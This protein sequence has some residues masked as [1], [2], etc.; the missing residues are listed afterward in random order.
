MR[1]KKINIRFFLTVIIFGSWL[2]PAKNTPFK[3]SMIFTFYFDG[4][5]KLK[6]IL[7]T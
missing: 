6:N 4:S 2:D 7:I 5:G 3:I 1:V